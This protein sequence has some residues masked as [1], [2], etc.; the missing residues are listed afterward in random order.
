SP[1]IDLLRNDVVLAE[2]GGAVACVV[3]QT[4]QALDVRLRVEVVLGVRE[5][6]LPARVREQ[7]RVERGP[8]RTA[9]GDRGEA[10]TETHAVLRQ[11]VEVRRLDLRVA[12]ATEIEAEVVGDEQNDVL[13]RRVRSAGA[14]GEQEDGKRETGEPAHGSTPGVSGSWRV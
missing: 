2:D 10:V 4:R 13:P 14:G 3:E 5:S 9:R 11:T 1:R 6:V 7:P 12:V 8:A